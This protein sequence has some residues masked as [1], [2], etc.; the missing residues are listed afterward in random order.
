MGLLEVTAARGAGSG[1]TIY[2]SSFVT[3]KADFMNTVEMTIESLS[4]PGQ[5]GVTSFSG[6][7][8]SPSAVPEPS[9]VILLSVGVA[10]M[11]FRRWMAHWTGTHGTM[12]TRPVAEPPAQDGRRPRI[13]GRPC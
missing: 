13:A 7:D 1:G 4:A 8:Y 3:G 6:H 11:L 10:S 12:R 2:P 9:S 5:S